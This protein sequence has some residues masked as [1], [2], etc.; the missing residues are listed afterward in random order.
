[1]TDRRDGKAEAILAAKIVVKQNA[2]GIYERTSASFD[3]KHTA[4]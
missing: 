1:L 4:K 2:A 3:E